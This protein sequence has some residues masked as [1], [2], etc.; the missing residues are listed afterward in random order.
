MHY[1]ASYPK[2]LLFSSLGCVV[3]GKWCQGPRA[4]LGWEIPL[5]FLAFYWW[6]GNSGVHAG[7]CT[8]SPEHLSC[9]ACVLLPKP[10]TIPSPA[11]YVAFRYEWSSWNAWGFCNMLFKSQADIFPTRRNC[12]VAVKYPLAFPCL[13]SQEPNHYTSYVFTRGFASIQRELQFKP[14]FQVI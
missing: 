4:C 13:F 8:P 11:F 7:P 14:Y 12:H 9:F 6:G 2:Q 3:D 1:C 10:P 5:R